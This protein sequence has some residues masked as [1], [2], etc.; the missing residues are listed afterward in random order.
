MLDATPHARAAVFLAKFESALASGEAEAVADMFAPECC[1]RDL[2][3]FTW[4]G[5]LKFE[6]QHPAV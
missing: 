6:V 3:S 4:N 5:G 1:W 2:V